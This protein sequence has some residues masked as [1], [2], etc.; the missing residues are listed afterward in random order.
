MMKSALALAA[1]ATAAAPALAG[2]IRL[3][4]PRAGATLHDTGTAM[5]VYYDTTET[6]YEVVATYADAFRGPARL[7]L[8]LADGDAV[9]FGLPGKQGTLYHFAR[10]GEAV[11]VRAAR[12]GQVVAAN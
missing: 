10:D 5:T 12:T 7:S 9:S 8:E 4:A 2:E 1:L 6:G 11:V 3:D